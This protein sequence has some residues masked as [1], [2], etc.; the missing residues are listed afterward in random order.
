[1][2]KW[3]NIDVLNLRDGIESWHDNLS[4]S[5]VGHIRGPLIAF[6]VC[7]VR[8]MAHRYVCNSV[9]DPTC[10][11]MISSTAGLQRLIRGPVIIF[12]A[13]V[14]DS[15]MLASDFLVTEP[16]SWPLIFAVQEPVILPD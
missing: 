5:S 7:T 11:P 13:S 14:Q 3:L 12:A 4:S 1:M 2:D 8:H 15:T 6:T 9:Q 16:D 10:G